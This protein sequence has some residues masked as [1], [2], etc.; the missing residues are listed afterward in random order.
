[1]RC[2]QL[3]ICAK[4][5]NLDSI[6]EVLGSSE[7]FWGHAL[8]RIG[9][10]P[11]K[12][13][14]VKPAIKTGLYSICF[15]MKASNLRGKIA[16]ALKSAGQDVR[17]AKLFLELPLIIELLSARDKALTA[18]EANGGAETPYGKWCAVSGSRKP[19]EVMAEVAQAWEMKL[20][21]PVF[22]MAKTTKDFQVT[23]YQFDGVTVQFTRRA[24]QWK[25]RIRA[26][27]EQE[28]EKEGIKTG[29][30]WKEEGT[31]EGEPRRAIISRLDTFIRDE[32]L[33][34]Q[35]NLS[36]RASLNPLVWSDRIFRSENDTKR[37]PA[38]N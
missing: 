6:N 36:E 32:A 7:G 20:L 13:A 16:C 25:R 17:L 12:Q 15:G 28:A 37:H 19:R 10:P 34:G 31:G 18:I 27:I 26:E 4:L 11:E 24:E 23:V 22:K 5:W 14:E 8:N 33:V 2:A 21:M 35:E 30:E 1:L 38:Q 3:A 29:W 9:V